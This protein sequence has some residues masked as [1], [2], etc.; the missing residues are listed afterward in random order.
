[1]SKYMVHYDFELPG[2]DEVNK[3]HSDVALVEATSPEEA[4]AIVCSKERAGSERRY[5]YKIEVHHVCTPQ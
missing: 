4:E 1:M 3:M 2:W 5:V